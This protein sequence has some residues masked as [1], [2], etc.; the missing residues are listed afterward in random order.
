MI[1]TLIKLRCGEHVSYKLSD[2]V[3]VQSLT[4]VV[5]GRPGVPETGLV[6]PLELVK[7]SNTPQNS[8]V[9]RP[10]KAATLLGS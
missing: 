8:S 9:I 4:E 1:D 2:A 6:K 7:V 5:S 10:K 3:S